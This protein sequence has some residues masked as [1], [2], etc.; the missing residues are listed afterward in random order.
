ME[1]KIYQFSSKKVS[2]YFDADFAHLA[3]LADNANSIIITDDHIAKHHARK[4]SGWR[5]IV[6]K[7]GEGFK[8]Q[9]TVDSIIDQLIGLEA[10]RK[11][12]LVGVGGGV[13][14]DITGYVAAVYMRGLKFGFVPT[15][16]LGMVDASIGGKNG[17]DVG[18]FKNMVGT[19]RQP[20]FLLYDISLL[21]TLPQE[22]WVNGFAEIIKHACIK[23]QNLFKELEQHKIEYYQKNKAALSK[24]IR[25]NAVIKSEVVKKDEFENGERKL[26]NFGHTIGHAIENVYDLPHGQA[27]SIGMVAAGILSEQFTNFKDTARIISLL[28]KYGLPTLAEFNAKKAFEVLKMDKKKVQQNLNYILLNK[29]GEGVVKA[30]PIDQLEKLIH[31]IVRAR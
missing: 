31:S 7:A 23:S 17:I 11:T 22:E 29:I 20:E 14:T 27:I 3:K 16:V 9:S 19:I 21:K 4:L 18:V 15:S 8:V 25:I 24:L 13:I 12:I 26:L 5:T 1:K 10:D 30:I 28:T 6:V 2:Y